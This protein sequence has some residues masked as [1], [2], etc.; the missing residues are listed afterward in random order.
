MSEQLSTHLLEA[1]AYLKKF[2]KHSTAL[3]G[4]RHIDPTLIPAS[5]RSTYTEKM[6]IVT[7]AIRDGEI[8]KEDFG[9]YIGF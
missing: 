9:K 4:F 7:K 3:D 1:I 2:V 6:M 8:T 5:E